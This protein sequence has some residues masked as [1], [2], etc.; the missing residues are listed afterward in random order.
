MYVVYYVMYIHHKKALGE[1]LGHNQLFDLE[2]AAV[3]VCILTDFATLLVEG[4]TLND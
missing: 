2:E 1:Y 4:I 3:V